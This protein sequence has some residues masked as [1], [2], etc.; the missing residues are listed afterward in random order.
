MLISLRNEQLVPYVHVIK[1]TWLLDLQIKGNT[2]VQ[3]PTTESSFRGEVTSHNTEGPVG[4]TDPTLTIKKKA[5]CAS[6]EVLQ[7]KII[8]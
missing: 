2:T 5:D 3:N 8:F 6:N 4:P 1:C 7:D